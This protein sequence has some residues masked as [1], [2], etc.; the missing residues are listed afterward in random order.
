[1]S[2]VLGVW[3]KRWRVWWGNFLTYIVVLCPYCDLWDMNNDGDSF[4]F[5]RS[6]VVTFFVFFW[7]D[8]YVIS[9][10]TR[11]YR[12]YFKS[13]CEE[14]WNNTNITFQTESRLIIHQKNSVKKGCCCGSKTSFIFHLFPLTWV[15]E[16]YLNNRISPRLV[17]LH[18]SKEE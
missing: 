14:M 18:T 4:C 3:R 17:S 15:L 1:M 7:K 13:I 8:I 10:K 6:N 16:I 12:K 2:I 11:K 9:M 5:T